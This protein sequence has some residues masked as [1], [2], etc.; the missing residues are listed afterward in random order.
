M[1]PVSETGARMWMELNPNGLSTSYYF[2]YISD[3]AYRANPPGNPFAGALKTAVATTTGTVF[4]DVARETSGVLPAAATYHYRPVASHSGEVERAIG[5]EHV[6]VTKEAGTTSRLPDNRAWEMVSPIDKGGGAIAAPEELFG[7]GDLQAAAAGAAVT[8]GSARTFGGAAGAPPVSQYVSRREPTGWITEDVSAP[9]QSGDYGD[10]PDG[11]P[12]RVFSADLSRALLFGGLAC[13]GGLEGCPA[14]NQP[15]PGSGAPAGYMAYYLRQG[16]QF[17]SLLGAGD[18]AH[19]SPGVL[20]S[21]LEVSFAAATPDLSHIVLSS[22]AAL[23]ADTTQVP[24]GSGQCDPEE[25]NLYDS[26]SAGLKAVNLLPGSSLATPGAAIASALGAISLD[27]SRIYWTEGGGLYLREGSQTV[28]VDEAVGGGGAFQT[29]SADGSIALFTKAGH[30]YRFAAAGKAVSDL[31]PAGGVVGVLGASADGGY[32]YFQDAAG[33]ELWHGGTIAPVA[34]SGP[35]T[36]L[37]GSYPPATATARVSADG[38][39]LA[40]L[41]KAALTEF[42]NL[43]A[44]TKQ[45]DTELYIYSASIGGSEPSLICASCNPTGERPEGSASIPGALVN[46]STL[47]Y[48]SRALSADG[49]R[50]F[51]ETDDGISDKD[52]NASGDVYEWEAEGRGGCARAFGCV[53]PISS[54]AGSGGSFVDASTDGS[55]VYFLTSDSLV[56]ADPGSIDLYDARV[57]GGLPGPADPPVCVGDSCQS[58]PREPEDPTPGTLVPNPGNPPLHVFEPK[59]KR[60]KLKLHRRHHHGRGHG[61]RAGGRTR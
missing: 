56:K 9:L 18:V 54:V 15:L 61:Q 7:G 12:Y 20:P 31:T 42:D 48:R 44:I 52:T 35:A 14:P 55:D 13:R 29:A 47:A 11:A 6:F 30:L 59:K 40:F 32:V 37:P 2:E 8:Y 45:P 22:C 4:L 28:A 57:N 24:G 60:K 3:A 23:S 1:S 34:A 19:S 41:S 27:G 43:D 46:G 25:Q 21:D 39:H 36:A 17:S 53:A 38:L 5:A 33:L 10:R 26:S 58:L 50:L 51:F 49:S 16:G